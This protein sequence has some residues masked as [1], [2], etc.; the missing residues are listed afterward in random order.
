[1]EPS[2][3]ASGF[4]EW[5]ASFGEINERCQGVSDLRELSD[6]II[7]GEMLRSIDD[8]WFGPAARPSGDLTENWVLQLNHL[9]RLYNLLVRYMDE[10]IQQP[11]HIFDTPNLSNIVREGDVNEIMVLCTMISFTSVHCEK[12]QEFIA[13]MQ[14][15]SENAQATLMGAIDL[16]MRRMAD[17][18]KNSANNNSNNNNGNNNRNNNN[19]NNNIDDGFGGDI[20]HR[21]SYGDIAGGRHSSGGMRDSLGGSTF[22]DEDPI[23]R[24]Q[25]EMMRLYGDKEDLEKVVR[26][27]ENQN[28]GLQDKLDE[29][30]GIN[31]DYKKRLGEMESAVAKA[32]QTGKTDFL[33][34]TEL[35][36]L[37]IDLDKA[38]SKRQEAEHRL[39]E[40]TAIT[41]Q[42]S[43]RLNEQSHLAEEAAKLRDQLQ[44]QRHLADRLQKAENVIDKYKR[45]L[46][47][48]SE[49]KN[50]VK[51]LEYDLANATERANLIEDEYRKLAQFK[52]MMESYKEQ[53][54][55]AESR[56]NLLQLDI[57]RLEHELSKVTQ[58][59]DALA[60]ERTRSDEQIHNLEQAL[61]EFELSGGQQLRRSSTEDM[62]DADAGAP[63]TLDRALA[64]STNVELRAK[65]ARLESE[66][67]SHRRRDAGFP[68]AK[69]A[70]SA[71]ERITLL[72]SLL[73]DSER[74]K[75]HLNDE[76]Q[77]SQRT[78]LE[79][80]DQ[81]TDMDSTVEA[82]SAAN[83]ASTGSSGTV[84]VFQ[85][86]RR[87]ITDLESEIGTLREGKTQLEHQLAQRDPNALSLKGQETLQNLMD[88]DGKVKESEL[89]EMVRTHDMLQVWYSDLENSNRELNQRINTLLL[90]KDELHTKINAAKDQLLA[91]EREKAELRTQFASSAGA[92]A[93]GADGAL[94]ADFIEERA[95]LNARINELQSQIELLRNE[96]KENTEAKNT[97]R[98]ELQMLHMKILKSKQFIVQQ[99][100]I[101]RE[102]KDVYGN[103][104]SK[105]D[106]TT[107]KFKAE[108]DA[109]YKQ[110]DDERSRSK[111]LVER[112]EREMRM[113]CSAWHTLG[114][115]IMKM[116]MQREG[117]SISNNS[118][119]GG[120]M[121]QTPS[122]GRGGNKASVPASPY[123][124]PMAARRAITTM[125]TPT[126]NNVATPVVGGSQARSW[127]GQQRMHFTPGNYPQR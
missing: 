122:A 43:R 42:L 13:R 30:F 16:C 50:H 119:G 21:G 39:E 99:D 68:A 65:V 10:V 85:Q 58:S 78:I 124:T 83:D 37:R 90:E 106:E 118:S 64:D 32:E 17:T 81:V 72:E 53:I 111:A 54:N 79:L 63:R 59:R 66:L 87:R 3:V 51:K 36:H 82:L 74:S 109:N 84:E 26:E 5:V 125:A 25:A 127:L 70:S 76:L 49:S 95:N 45:K 20:G 1:M 56:G 115:D 15:L 35:D 107:E 4:L 126:I 62:D 121:P 61:R 9:K 22:G 89:Q 7:I 108:I 60:A 48:L 31:S 91:S 69:G 80:K 116:Q 123:S 27:L 14:M 29:Q 12:N 8:E 34:R 92:G 28:N 40:Q 57:T 105:L 113:V 86:M 96:A 117:T 88:A 98:A 73:E 101:L 102:L 38:E 41:N 77:R 67:A 110:V 33:M 19:N 120:G 103:S 47:D 11:T 104:Q 6:G 94:S 24:L 75:K 46:E 93:V 71:G 55:K 2:D 114:M 44:E 97:M 18:D 23:L 112:V 52:P 100:R